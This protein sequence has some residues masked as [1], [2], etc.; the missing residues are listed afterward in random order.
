[1]QAEREKGWA[2]CSTRLKAARQNCILVPLRATVDCEGRI[3]ARPP[4]PRQPFDRLPDSA[5]LW[6]FAASRPLEVAERDVLLEAVDAFLDQWNAHRVP[7]D[8]ARA[9]HYDQFLVVGVDEEGA[10]VSG[11]SVD[12]LVR[13]MKAL[14]QQLGVDLVDHASVF[15]RDGGHVRR[16]T[17]DDFAQ[18]VSE[19]AVTR[20]TCVFDNT[21]QTVGALRAGAWEAPAGRTWHGRAFF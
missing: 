12:A 16:A 17:R 19:G 20:D 2:L 18:A 21:V 15:Y 6:V 13:T 11:C 9:L 5:R 4:M 14:G 10:G 8:C 3:R 7:L 1:M